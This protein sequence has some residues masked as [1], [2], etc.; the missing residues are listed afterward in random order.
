[1]L[2]TNYGDIGI[3]LANNES[4]CTV[5]SFVSLTKQHFFDSTDCYRTY[6]APDG[7]FVLCGGP[8]DGT[9][10]PGYEFADEYPADQYQQGD[11]A[12][13][14]TVIYPRGT[15]FSANDGKPGTNGSQFALV[16]KDSEMEPQ[17]TVFGTIDQ[18][19]LDTLDKIARLGIAGDRQMGAPASPVTINSVR[20]G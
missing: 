20:L 7:G 14:A 19:G 17:S 10:G 16:Y 4:P 9:G 11:S 3:Q 5:N 12:L 2:S 18:A 13:R 1:V 6:S 15:V 8:V